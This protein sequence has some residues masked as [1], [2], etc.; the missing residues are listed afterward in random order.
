MTEPVKFIPFDKTG[1]S[2][3]NLITDEEHWVQVAGQTFFIPKNIGFYVDSLVVNVKTG[4]IRRELNADEFQVGEYLPTV[5]HLT[6]IDAACTIVLRDG[7]EKD[8]ILTLTY[9]AVGGEGGVS[10]DILDSIEKFVSQSSDVKWSELD[11][12]AVFRPKKGHKHR[13]STAYGFGDISKI[14]KAMVD[15]VRTK[16]E[17]I[18]RTI[19][20]RGISSVGGEIFTASSRQ[21]QQLYQRVIDDCDVADKAAIGVSDIYIENGN[22]IRVFMNEVTKGSDQSTRFNKLYGDRDYSMALMRVLNDKQDHDGTLIDAPKYIDGLKIW[23]DF[24]NQSLRKDTPTQKQIT[25]ACNGQLWNVSNANFATDALEVR[26]GSRIEPLAPVS[27]GKEFT[28]VCVYKL[29]DVNSLGTM[30]LLETDKVIIEHRPSLGNAFVIKDK[31]GKLLAKAHQYAPAEGTVGFFM[32][33]NSESQGRCFFNTHAPTLTED[34]PS[35]YERWFDFSLGNVVRVG[36]ITNQFNL[37]HFLAFD[38]ALGEYPFDLLALYF[39]KRCSANIELIPNC[40]FDRGLSEFSSQYRVEYPTLEYPPAA[41]DVWWLVK[42]SQT[43]NRALFLGMNALSNLIE[44]DPVYQS[45]MVVHGLSGTKAFWVKTL[46]SGIGKTH[47]LEVTFRSLGVTPALK[48]SLNGVMQKNPVTIITSLGR[49]MARFTFKTPA[50]V[51]VLSLSQTSSSNNNI[52]IIDRISMT[53]QPLV[54]A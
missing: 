28:L 44:K 2:P 29:P 18:E 16:D 17:A 3:K 38:T 37:L 24:Q 43:S 11:H 48:L 46:T 41:G 19:L 22:D 51:T 1:K 32:L 9:Q 10:Y 49:A 20:Q 12:P 40:D 23:L 31:S 42:R 5:C 4:D 7:L 45:W 26:D 39:K 14:V 50:E 8:T 33:A 53:R 36:G 27:F 25:D 15:I 52:F 13:L 6:N 34:H 21:G 35:G 47:V 54:S 30:T